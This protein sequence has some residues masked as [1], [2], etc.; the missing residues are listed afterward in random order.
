MK[1]NMGTQTPTGEDVAYAMGHGQAEWFVQNAQM[2]QR[3][4]LPTSDQ[5][6]EASPRR[7]SEHGT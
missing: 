7:S 2:F 3:E 1:M 6:V 4:P 5:Y